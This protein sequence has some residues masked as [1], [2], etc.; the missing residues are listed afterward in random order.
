MFGNKSPQKANIV[1]VRPKIS[2]VPSALAKTKPLNKDRKLIRNRK[3]E[4]RKYSKKL[5]DEAI[6]L[7]KMPHVNFVRLPQWRL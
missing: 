2:I 3:K 5:R 7:T 4:I 1:T 6:A